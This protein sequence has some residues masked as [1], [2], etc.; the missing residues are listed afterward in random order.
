MTKIYTRTGD[1]GE[2]GLIGGA[3]V[4]KDDPRIA[5][6]GDVDELNAALGLSRTLLDQPRAAAALARELGAIQAVLFELGAEL[7]D[8]ARRSA[9]RVRA[10]DT[11]TLEASIDRMTARLPALTHFILPGGSKAGAALHL[12]RAVCRRAERAVVALSR[13][14]GVNRESLLYLNRLSDWLFTAARAANRLAKKPETPWSPRKS[15]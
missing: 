9:S 14:A 11:K 10:A 3:R 7:A 13:H 2:T 12:A 1:A 6:V 15:Q 8:P 5:A 4:R